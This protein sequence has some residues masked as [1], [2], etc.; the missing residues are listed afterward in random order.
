MFCGLFGGPSASSG[1]DYVADKAGSEKGSSGPST[2]RDP[3]GIW[4]GGVRNC[5][6]DRS[7]QKWMFTALIITG[8]AV[9]VIAILV[10]VGTGMINNIPPSPLHHA[11]APVPL[12]LMDMAKSIGY[13]GALYTLAAGVPA[14]MLMIGGGSYGLA[15]R[16]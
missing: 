3:A 7:N 14:G 10:G 2:P 6:A 5:F 15:R 16:A 9:A 12:W 13:Y 8:V 11:P 1:N 4:C